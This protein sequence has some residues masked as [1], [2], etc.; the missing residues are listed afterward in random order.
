MT[1]Q[2]LIIGDLTGCPIKLIFLMTSNIAGLQEHKNR[3]CVNTSGP[4]C[5]TRSVHYTL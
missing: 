3:V 2:I 5:S 4:G 1:K